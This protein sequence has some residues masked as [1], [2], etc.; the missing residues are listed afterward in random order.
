MTFND[1]EAFFWMKKGVLSWTKGGDLMSIDE[2]VK[3][4]IR[5][6]NENFD[7]EEERFNF[8]LSCYVLLI[9]E[10]SF[11]YDFDKAED[12]GDFISACYVL[13]KINNNN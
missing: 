2:R 9:N 6:L 3:N 13:S 11:N 12:D 10:L 5:L 1:I 7:N 8:I 4:F